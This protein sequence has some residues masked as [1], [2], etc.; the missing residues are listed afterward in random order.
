MPIS[1][2]DAS[3]INRVLT[4]TLDRYSPKISNELARNDGIIA[5]FGA[6]GRIKI[7]DGGERAIETLDVTENPNVGFR[8]RYADIPVALADSRKQAKYAYATIDG[9]VVLND[10]EK[11]MNAG[12]SKIY[13]LPEAEVT[14]FKNTLV[15]KIADAL[16]ATTPGANDP[17]SILTIIPDTA[18]ASQSTTTGELSRSTYRWWRSQYD[19]TS[20]DLSAAAGLEILLAFYMQS[21]AKGASKLDQPDFGLTTGTLFA[22]LSSQADVLRRFSPNDK[23]LKLGFSNI[24]VVNATIIADPAMTAGDIRFINSNF[25]QLQALRTP[26]MQNVGERPNTLPVSFKPFKDAYN[27]L[28]AVSIGYLS[29][30]LTCSSLQRQ[31]IQTSCS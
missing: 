4:T 16:R 2:A 5:L 14:N 9:A 13:D 29:F 28:H 30:A 24:E 6:N 23:M 21:C 26:S 19:S 31:G 7:N 22:A 15:R 12:D 3:K 25:C 20:A 27:S 11:A 1:G 17:E 18:V 8:S 10:I